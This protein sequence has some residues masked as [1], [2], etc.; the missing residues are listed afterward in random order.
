MAASAISLA[1]TGSTVSRLAST[2][3]DPS[4][5][6]GPTVSRPASVI[7]TVNAWVALT[8]A[9]TCLYWALTAYRL[10]IRP[11]YGRTTATTRLGLCR[12]TA[13]NGLNIRPTMT[14]DGLA[15]DGT[16]CRLDYSLSNPHRPD[17]TRLGFT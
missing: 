4:A 13:I 17:S 12:L 11:K 3:T 15:G 10:A 6:T 2:C 9:C 16:G 1:I 7:I 14:T 8:I 5:I